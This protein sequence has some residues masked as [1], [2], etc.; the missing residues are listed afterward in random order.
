MSSSSTDEVGGGGGG[1]GGAGRWALSSHAHLKC[2]DI[3]KSLEGIKEGED[4]ILKHEP[5]ILHVRCAN[6]E[7]VSLLPF[8]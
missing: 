5:A 2:G 8:S 4:A 7:R 6:M 1:K 3:I